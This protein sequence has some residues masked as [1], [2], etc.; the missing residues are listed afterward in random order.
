VAKDKKPRLRT[1]EDT[2]TLVEHLREL[3]DRVIKCMMALALG[4]LIVFFLY[5][6]I[7]NFLRGPYKDVCLQNPS[8]NCDGNFLITDPLDGFA[9]RVR[10][11]G[12]GGFI[13]ALPVIL[14]QVWRFVVP[15]LHPREKRYAVPFVLSS[16]ALFAFGGFIAWFTLPFAL[17]FLVAFS[18]SGVTAS[19]NPGKY[20]RLVTLMVMAFG[21]GFLFPVVLVFLQ[22]VNVLTPRR[23]S[24]WRRQAIV[25][26]FIVAAVITP[27]GDPYSLLALAIPMYVFYE[28]SILIGWIVNRRRAKSAAS[29]APSPA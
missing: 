28:L 13:I 26:I 6:P 25:V 17:Q 1:P 29:A 10:V 14:W 11:S 21:L 16:V 3:R 9:T 7:L 2:A 5:N 24:S 18:G 12:Y 15:G 4:G 22:L 20:I 27:S 23:L 19:F 8:F